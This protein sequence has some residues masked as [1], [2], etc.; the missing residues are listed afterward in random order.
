MAFATQDAVKEYYGQDLKSSAD[1]KTSACCPAE[2]MP[3]HV[4]RLLANVHEE[5]RNRFYGCGSPIPPVL[6]GARFLIW[7]AEPAGTALSC[8]NWLARMAK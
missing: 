2:A 8:H 1:L 6:K 3:P 5:V 4:R 7:A